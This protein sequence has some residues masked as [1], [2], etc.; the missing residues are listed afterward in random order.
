MDGGT[1]GVSTHPTPGLEIAKLTF[2]PIPVDANGIDVD[3]RRSGRTRPLF[4]FIDEQLHRL[5]LL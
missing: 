5:G 4:F 2:T 3:P 1:S